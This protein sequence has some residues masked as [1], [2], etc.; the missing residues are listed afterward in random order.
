MARRVLGSL[1]VDVRTNTA[2]FTQG[3]A[4]ADRSLQKFTS[5][6]GL[7][8]RAMAGFGAAGAAFAAGAL[9]RGV[10]NT[11]REIEKLKATLKTLEGSTS[12]ANNAFAF[13]TKFAAT[14][15]FSLQQVT[16]AF[17]K[18]KA[19][20]L[21]PSE[22]ALRSYGNTASAMGKS[23]EQFVEAVADAITGEFERLKEFGIKSKTEGDRVKFTFQGITTE[24]GK[25]AD[26]IEGFLRKIGKNQ[27]AGALTA[28]ANTLD[29]IMSNISDAFTRLQV[30][31]D[32]T[33]DDLKESLQGFLDL[34]N[35]PSTIKAASTFTSIF[36]GELNRTLE[37]IVTVTNAMRTLGETLAAS[38]SGPNDIKR[39]DEQIARLFKRI[40]V[41][42]RTAGPLYPKEKSI[43]DIKEIEAQI[44]SL[45]ERRKLLDG[46]LFAPD[47]GAPKATDLPKINIDAALN[48][49]PFDTKKRDTKSLTD[50]ENQALRDKAALYAQTRTAVEQYEIQVARLQKLQREFGLDQ[51]VYNRAI[52]QYAEDLRDADPA[53]AAINKQQEEAARVFEA[54]RKPLEKLY[55][56]Y[57]RLQKLNLDPETFKRAVTQ[58]AEGYAKL[59]KKGKEATDNLSVYAEQAARNTQDAFADFLFDPFQNGLD[60][61]LIGFLKV[62]QRIAAEQAAAAIFD[63]K[64]DGGLGLGNLI[65]GGIKSLFG[66][67]K[68]IGG[69]VNPNQ[70]FLVGERGPELFVPPT[71]GNIVPNDQ[72]GSARSVT[73]IQ[74]IA[75]PRPSQYRKAASR[76]ALDAQR[77]FQR[78]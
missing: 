43:R 72:M 67:A 35:D 78:A 45:Q 36:I 24:V 31:E 73:V 40:D 56:E 77:Q 1:V 68:A 64:A 13:I 15:P 9:L 66:G 46:T 51:E 76:M 63:S 39:I 69:P 7:A 60:G 47:V 14:T 34:L 32:G 44:A 65:Q 21:D 62:I 23:L 33:L 61:M 59:E 75:A 5:S 6:A 54:T 18:L 25:T 27:F 26:E 3:L 53:V 41:A 57:E 74:N 42:R 10:I 11:T 52:Q 22:D 58:A 48:L 55:A 71:R 8:Q 16:K 4:K 49:Q 17:I 29:G 30:A 70:A 50:E 2:K 19:L 20:G 28:Q 12:G 38:V 37:G